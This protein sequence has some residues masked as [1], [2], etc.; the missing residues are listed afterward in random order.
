MNVFRRRLRVLDTHTKT[1]QY[2]YYMHI[3]SGWIFF[4]VFEG[5]PPG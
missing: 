1:Y 4:I 3:V 5:A 2:Y